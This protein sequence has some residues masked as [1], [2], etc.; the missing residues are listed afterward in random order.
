MKSRRTLFIVNPVAGA[1]R[2]RARWAG[3]AEQ[4]TRDGFH[5]DRV[6]T[7]GPGDALRL[8]QEAASERDLLVAVGGD[9]T[10]F[11]VANGI[12]L[13]GAAQTCLGIVPCGTGNDAAQQA[14]IHDLAG[15]HRALLQGRS[16]IVDVVEARCQSQN[17]TLLRYALLYVSVGIT[18]EV[19][20]RTTPRVKR[21]FG[22]RLAYPVGLIRALRTYQPPRMR[23]TADGQVFERRFLAICASN[24]EIAGGGLRLA[25]GAK[26]DDGLFN[27]NL[28]EALGRWRAF[29]QVLRLARGWHV[30]HPKVRY[31]T[32][33]TL[34]VETDSPI[35]VQA[36]GDFVGTTPAR[37][38]LRPQA[39]RV[40]VP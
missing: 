8:A 6:E 13:A 15:A 11:E 36:D 40:L 14:G 27:V 31:F 30:H 16:R 32:A 17:E 9:G 2:A 38:Q 20:W 22:Q 5:G 3:L 34:A 29:A 28:I 33:R 39:L 7:T 12:L 21:L 1:G 19:R 23:A 10:V 18:G 35:E 37:F 26:M 25:P 24:S 4:L